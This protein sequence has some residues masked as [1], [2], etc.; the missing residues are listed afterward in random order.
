VDPNTTIHDLVAQIQT[1]HGV[2]TDTHVFRFSPSGVQLPGNMPIMSPGDRTFL[3][4][5]V[6]RLRSQLD[7]ERAVGKVRVEGGIAHP[8]GAAD[9]KDDDDIE[10]K[11]DEVANDAVRVHVYDGGGTKVWLRGEYA[12]MTAD[13]LSRQ[14]AR[15]ATKPPRKW[16]VL[17]A[18]A[19]ILSLEYFS[20]D[21]KRRLL[22]GRFCGYNLVGSKSSVGTKPLTMNDIHEATGEIQFWTPA[23]FAAVMAKADITGN[24]PEFEDA[25]DNDA[26]ILFEQFTTQSFDAIVGD[27]FQ[28]DE[29]RALAEQLWAD[30]TLID[31]ESKCD[32]RR[33]FASLQPDLRKLQERQQDEDLVDESKRRAWNRA[34][35][36]R[37]YGV[38]RKND[39]LPPDSDGDSDDS[40][41]PAP[42][43]PHRP[44][45]VVSVDLVTAAFRNTHVKD[46][47]SKTQLKNSYY[48]LNRWVDA[49]EARDWKSMSMVCKEFVHTAKNLGQRIIEDKVSMG[50]LRCFLPRNMGGIAGG[51]KFIEKGI[52]IKF[53]GKS[54]RWRRGVWRDGCLVLS[55]Y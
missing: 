50:D 27:Y 7:A 1:T 36:G 24:A 9:A 42:P 32:A 53:A 11:A 49:F 16:D 29:L 8:R 20:P 22:R 12:T 23:K 13:E 35:V 17:V 54:Q 55:L 26:A 15:C 40:S 33:M 34:K 21:E 4:G 25:I 38:T 5:E 39:P 44:P 2:T 30:L 51:K 43:P 10:G 37:S 6:D 47:V 18:A 19:W 14:L 45:P 31:D 48:M 41:D 3:V 52:L 46:H 28:T